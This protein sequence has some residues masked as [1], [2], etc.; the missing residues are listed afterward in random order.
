MDV[1]FLDEPTAGVDPQAREDLWRIITSLHEGGQ[2]V[3]L[4]TRHLDEAE[5]LPTPCTASPAARATWP[6]RADRAD[7]HDTV[8]RRPGPPAARPAS[9]SATPPPHPQPADRLPHPDRTWLHAMTT[10]NPLAASPPAVVPPL[11]PARLSRADRTR[12]PR[13][14]A[15]PFRAAHP[16]RAPVTAVH[17]RGM[18]WDCGPG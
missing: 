8:R 10:A 11:R 1:L 6:S 3:V 5:A 15:Q 13:P 12:P 4:T 18:G 2:V 7:P 17:V 9:P 14:G 16:S